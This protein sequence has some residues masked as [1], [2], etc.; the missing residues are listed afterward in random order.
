MEAHQTH[1]DMVIPNEKPK[2]NKK[3]PE[4]GI[5]FTP[6]RKKPLWRNAQLISRIILIALGIFIL[7]CLA[8]AQ[9]PKYRVKAV[10]TKGDT[11]TSNT[12]TAL[13]GGAPYI[14][15]PNT[16]T[17]NGDGVNERFAL[18]LNNVREFHVWIYSSEGGIMAEWSNPSGYWDGK[19]GMVGMYV[20][21]IQWTGQDG[22]AREDFGKLVLV[23]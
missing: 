9:P 4:R 8:S 17:P 1:T 11:S 19:N 16:F 12:V 2:K 14:Y 23:R 10:S 21:H 6:P 18:Y 5:V 20:V 13:K 7:S 22:K 15:F 3:H